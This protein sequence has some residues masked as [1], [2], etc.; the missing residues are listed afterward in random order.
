MLE[1]KT[2][3][4]KVLRHFE[5]S[6]MPGFEPVAISELILRP[7]NGIWLQLKERKAV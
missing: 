7:E 6:V 3:V 5:L 4:S 1:M 2:T